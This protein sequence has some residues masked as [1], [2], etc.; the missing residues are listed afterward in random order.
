MAINEIKPDK[1]EAVFARCQD[2]S[3]IRSG[4][5]CPY[6]GAAETYKNRENPNDVNLWCFMIRAF[7]VDTSSECRN[8]NRWFTL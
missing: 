7:R 3:P 4:L 5:E 1:R 8:C 2:E 6:C